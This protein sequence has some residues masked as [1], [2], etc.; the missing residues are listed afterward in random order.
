V[1]REFGLLVISDEIYGEVDHRGVHRSIAVSYAE[2]TIITTGLSK[3]CGAGGWRLGVAAFPPELAELAD[4][5]ANMASETYTSTSAPIQYAAIAAFR[6]DKAIGRYLENSR[7]VL[8]LVQ[9]YV[10]ERLL[11]CGVS[12]PL[13]TGGFYLFCNFERFRADLA[14]RG[15]GSSDAFAEAL[16]LETGFAALP[17]TAFGR[18]PGEL[19]LRLSYVDFDGETALRRAEDIADAKAFAQVCPRIVRA[20]DVLT[21]WLQELSA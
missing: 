6:Q 17:G 7:R 15:I 14:R 2:G 1:A 18:G 10:R 11:A 20:M 3:W 19:L 9:R 8:S 5:V 21:E 12:V 4:V 16:L 13:G